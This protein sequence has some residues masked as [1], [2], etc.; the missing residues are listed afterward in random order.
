MKKCHE[1]D[2]DRGKKEDQK[3]QSSGKAIPKTEEHRSQAGSD[4]RHQQHRARWDD[5]V[6]KDQDNRDQK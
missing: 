3:G 6:Q 2:W 4:P 5:D 1:E